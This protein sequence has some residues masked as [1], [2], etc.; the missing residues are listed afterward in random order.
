MRTMIENCKGVF[1]QTGV[2]ASGED[3]SDNVTFNIN[4]EAAH[5]HSH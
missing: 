1:G 5:I 2:V 3:T 4:L